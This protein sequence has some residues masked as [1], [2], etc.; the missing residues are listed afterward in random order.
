MKTEWPIFWCPQVWYGT[1]GPS[2]LKLLYY[3]DENPLISTENVL[4]CRDLHKGQT[5]QIGACW[6]ELQQIYLHTGKK[7]F[8]P[9]R[10]QFAP[11]SKVALLTQ[12][13]AYPDYWCPPK[14][15]HAAILHVR[16]KFYKLIWFHIS[17]LTNITIGPPHNTVGGVQAIG[18]H[19]NWSADK[20]NRPV[21]SPTTFSFTQH[22]KTWDTLK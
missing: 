4:C 14:T 10:W 9:L 16:T 5:N 22:A 1:P 8:H 6:V 7:S 13:L 3:S 17:H 12:D 18:L 15:M 19:C 20:D 2:G 11:F 21:L